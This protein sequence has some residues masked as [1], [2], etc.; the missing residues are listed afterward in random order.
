[1]PSILRR[2]ITGSL[3]ELLS[4]ETGRLL[5]RPVFFCWEWRVGL[6]SEALR[7]QR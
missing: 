1:M 3:V 7:A 6:A 4:W 2:G 5:G